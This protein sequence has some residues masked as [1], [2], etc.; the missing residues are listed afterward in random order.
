[1]SLILLT[2]FGVCDTRP[3][4]GELVRKFFS[5][6]IKAAIRSAIDTLVGTQK[7]KVEA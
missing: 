3:I 7:E 2:F 1:M 5:T 6:V 4:Y